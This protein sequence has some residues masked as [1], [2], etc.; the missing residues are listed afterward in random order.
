M[1]IFSVLVGGDILGIMIKQ[2]KEITGTTKKGTELR[3]SQYAAYLSASDTNLGKTSPK[4][5]RKR[6][7]LKTQTISTSRFHT[8]EQKCGILFLLIYEIRLSVKKYLSRFQKKI[9]KY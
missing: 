6:R 8:Q 3:V 7:H 2:N 1:D 9:K 4:T 5:R